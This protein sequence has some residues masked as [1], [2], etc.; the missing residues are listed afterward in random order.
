MGLPDTSPVPKKDSMGMDYIP[1]YDGEEPDV[2]GAVKINPA[3]VQQLGVAIVA[4][5]ERRLARTIRAV[6]TIQA[7]ERR[8]FVVNTKFEGWIEKLHVNATGQPVRR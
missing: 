7:D 1:V 5:E 8:L 4:A 3:K 6:G 2:A